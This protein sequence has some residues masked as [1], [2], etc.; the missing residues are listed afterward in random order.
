MI[1]TD[2]EPALKAREGWR[3]RRRRDRLFSA[4]RWTLTA[5]GLCWLLLVALASLHPA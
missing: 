2:L 1:Q 4:L 3:R 5:L